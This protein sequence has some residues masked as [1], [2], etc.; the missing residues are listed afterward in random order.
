MINFYGNLTKQ[1]NAGT[2]ASAVTNIGKGIS[3]SGGWANNGREL[4]GIL[5]TNAG[6]GQM[7]TLGVWGIQKFQAGLPC[8][9]GLSL[10]VAASG[11]FVP[12]S[13]GLFEVGMC[14]GLDGLDGNAVNSGSNGTIF[15]NGAKVFTYPLSA[16]AFS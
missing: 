15:L 14:M 12:T 7:V 10:S 2:D 6:C 5:L 9:N 4:A 8:S 11:Y 3:F 13:L 1:L 16:G